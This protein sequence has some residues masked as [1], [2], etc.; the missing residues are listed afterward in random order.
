MGVL[1]TR[2]QLSSDCGN[3]SS[4]QG[5]WAL[6]CG[7]VTPPSLA[8]KQLSAQAHPTTSLLNAASLLVLMRFSGVIHPSPTVTQATGRD[9][10]KCDDVT[11]ATE[12][13]YLYIYSYCH[14]LISDSIICTFLNKSV[15]FF[16]P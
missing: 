13:D 2:V 12:Q 11:N 1:G 14:V 3:V 4:E 16:P 6:C 8:A 5:S 10:L 7:L 9:V 15:K